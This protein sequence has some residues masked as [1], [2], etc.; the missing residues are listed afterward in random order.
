MKVLNRVKQ[1]RLER[2]LS[3]RELSK[4]SGVDKSVIYRIENGYSYPTQITMMRIS[5]GLKHETHEVFD[6]NWKSNNV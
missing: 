1:L 5:R 6:L 3:L 4:L 2:G